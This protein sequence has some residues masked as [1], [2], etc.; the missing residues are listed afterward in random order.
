MG[1]G[2]GWRYYSCPKGILSPPPPQPSHFPSLI[3]RLKCL[4]MLN[5]MERTE[6]ETD[7]HDRRTHKQTH[8]TDGHIDTHDRHTDRRVTH[9]ADETDAERQIHATD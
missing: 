8:V 6:G 1:G 4:W 3:N 7:T 2:G 9:V 5:P